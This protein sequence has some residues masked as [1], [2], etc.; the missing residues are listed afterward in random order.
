[1]KAIADQIVDTKTRRGIALYSYLEINSLWNAWRSADTNTRYTFGDFI[2]IRLV[3][4]MEVNFREAVKSLVDKDLNAKTKAAKLLAKLPAKDTLD[5]LLRIEAKAFTLGDLVAHV[6]S[7]NKMEDI[8]SV[9][10]AIY[11]GNFR[12]DLEQTTENWVDEVELVKPTLITEPNV[13]Y[14]QVARTFS[15]RHILVHENPIQRPYDADEIETMIDHVKRFT[16]ALSWLISTMMR[17]PVART[18]QELNALAGKRKAE[19][20]KKLAEFIKTDTLVSECLE[21]FDCHLVWRRFVHLLADERSGLSLGSA[22]SGSIAPFRYADEV[23]ALNAW[24]VAEFEE[25]ARN[26]VLYP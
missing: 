23:A 12:A 14:Q 25:Y 6:V 16:G 19:S 20:E 24:K 26:S 1:M 5:A 9:M 11:N 8:F 13:T 10:D 2:P 7:C 21:D 22:I 4:I 17:G 15:V 3:T 18:Q